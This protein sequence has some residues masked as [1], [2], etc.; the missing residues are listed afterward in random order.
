[1]T[2]RIQRADRWAVMGLLM[3]LLLALLVCAPAR[4]LGAA[5]AQA[6][7]G[8]VLLTQAHGVWWQGQAGLEL[9]GGAGA[10]DRAALP[11][12]LSWRLRPSTSGLHLSLQADC[13]MTTPWAMRLQPRWLGRLALEWALE[14]HQSQ[15]PAAL[16]VGLGTP[17]NT[18][19]LQA[20]VS[21]QTSGLRVLFDQGRPKT[22]GQLLVE[23]RDVSSRLSTLQPMGSYRFVWQ[24]A[25]LAHSDAHNSDTLRLSTVQ[26][27]LQLHGQ[28]QWLA[29][30]L[31]FSGEA[32]AAPGREDALANLMNILGRRQGAKTLIQI[33]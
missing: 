12:Q 18:L 28:G 21:V 2:T 9:A 6:T 31:R 33:G 16:L 17:W 13:C 10:Q 26:G 8:R 25:G 19:Q 32:Q 24:G 29:G 14:T 11:G 30:R 22:E 7:G 23:L 5:L 15:W 4:W 1:M 20:T 27:A 3:G